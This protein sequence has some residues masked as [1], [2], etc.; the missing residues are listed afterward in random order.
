MTDLNKRLCLKLGILDQYTGWACKRNPACLM[1]EWTEKQCLVCEDREIIYALPDFSKPD[2]IVLL[3]EKMM[4]RE[5]WVDFAC[6]HLIYAYMSRGKTLF[7]LPTDLI[8]DK[9]GKFAKLC[10]EWLPEKEG[11]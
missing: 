10:D 6:E 11:V 7:A 4:E 9:T 2:G 5:D 8:T 1:T 3:I